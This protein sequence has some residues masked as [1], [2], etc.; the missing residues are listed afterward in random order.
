MREQ[1]KQQGGH[2]LNQAEAEAVAKVLLTP[3][4]TL[5]AGIVGKSAEFIANLAGISIPDGTRCLLADCG[6]VGRDFPW[7][8]EKLSPTLAFFVVD[9]VEQ[10][11]NRCQEILQFGGMG[12]TAGMHTQ[13]REAAIALRRADA[14]IARRDKFA[15]DARRDRFF[16]RS[17][18]FD[19]AWAA[20]R[21]AET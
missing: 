19:D 9:G 3:Q 17:A 4:R 8:I 1:F 6:G 12:H 10:G 5:N 11:A 14:R 15:D 16:D 7:S 20:V 18:A 13:D 2:F 21:G